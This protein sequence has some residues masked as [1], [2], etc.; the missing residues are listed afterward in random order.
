MTGSLPVFESFRFIDNIHYTMFDDLSGMI[1][2]IAFQMV[3]YFRT[4]LVFCFLDH[5]VV[6]ISEDSYSSEKIHEEKVRYGQNTQN[7]SDIATI[8]KTPTPENK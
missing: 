7:F 6:V 8:Q 1:G 5:L 4:F 2:S 3:G